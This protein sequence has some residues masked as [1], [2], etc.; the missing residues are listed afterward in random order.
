METVITVLKTL[1]PILFTLW[2]YDWFLKKNIYVQT[3]KHKT[4]Q[5]LFTLRGEIDSVFINELNVALLLFGNN[6]SLKRVIKDFSIIALNGTEREKDDKIVELLL[7]MSKSCGYRHIT[8][9][10]IRTIFVLK[11]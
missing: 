9:E 8:E 1:L 3:E 4:L 5:K 11:K 7:K 2:L 10:D 6:K